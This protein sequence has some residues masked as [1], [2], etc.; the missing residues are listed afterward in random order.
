MLKSPPR[1]AHWALL[2]CCFTALLAT[3]CGSDG[4]ATGSVCPPEPTLSYENFG[5]AFFETNCTSCHG[6][7][8]PESPNLSTLEQIQANRDGIDKQ[9]AAGPD[10]TN[11]FMPEGAS[12]SD[13]ERRKLGEWLA[14]GAPE[15]VP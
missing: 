10:A 9:A 7:N 11:T 2:A 1:S 13:A 3:A 6:P 12:V 15:T 5:Q 4:E 8:G 14:C